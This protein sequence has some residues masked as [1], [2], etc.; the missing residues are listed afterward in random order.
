MVWKCHVL[1]FYNHVFEWWNFSI[2]GDCISFDNTRILHG[3]KG[4]LA[5]KDSGRLYQGSYVAWDEIRSKMN[6]I[7]HMAHEEEPH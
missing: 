6:V 3:R 2:L 4:Y 1:E 7:K 5:T